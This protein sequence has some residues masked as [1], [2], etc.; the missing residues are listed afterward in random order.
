MSLGFRFLILSGKYGLLEA[1]DPIPYYD[2]LLLSS[3]VSEHAIRVADQLEALGVKQL[4]FFTR[5]LADDENVK[6]YIDCIKFASLKVGV[7]LK[8][9]ELPKS[10]DYGQENFKKAF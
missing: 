7:N 3:E 1:N 8:I 9:I 4:I 10:N 2:H 6:P 5:S